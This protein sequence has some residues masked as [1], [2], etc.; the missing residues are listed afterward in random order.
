MKEFI[1]YINNKYSIRW[2]IGEDIC[3]DYENAKGDTKSAKVMSLSEFELDKEILKLGSDD[4]LDDLK[5]EVVCDNTGEIW[6]NCLTLGE[7]KQCLLDEKDIDEG[8][9]S[10]REM[11]K[12]DK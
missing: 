7:A 5:Y 10:Y 2:V 11:R 12:E 9:L 8:P 3:Y 6:D 4:S 1:D